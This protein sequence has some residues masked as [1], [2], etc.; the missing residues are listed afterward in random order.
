MAANRIAW[1]LTTLLF[2][3]TAI[4]LF[5]SGYDGY[6]GVFLAVAAAAAINLFSF[7]PDDDPQQ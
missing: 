2:V 1:S 7:G 6:G 5:V 3:L 4:A